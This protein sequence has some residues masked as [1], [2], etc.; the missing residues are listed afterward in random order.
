MSNDPHFRGATPETLA[1]ALLRPTKRE[2][3]TPTAPARTDG[4]R[5]DKSMRNDGLKKSPS[6]TRD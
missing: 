6:G 3:Q 5:T 4:S 1:R 2:S